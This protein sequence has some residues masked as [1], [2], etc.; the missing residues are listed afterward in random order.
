M[1][2]GGF[3]PPAALRCDAR[4]RGL[5]TNIQQAPPGA[6][7]CGRAAETL[8]GRRRRDRS[9]TLL[10]HGPDRREPPVGDLLVQTKLLVPRARRELVP[11][12]RLDA[13]LEGASTSALTVVSAPAGFGKTTLLSELAAGRAR[14]GGQH[15][16]A[17]VSLDERDVDPRRFWSY[18]LHAVERSSPGAAASALDLLESATASLESVIVALVNEVSV[19]PGDVT[20]VLDD[21]HLVGGPAVDND[22]AFLLD[23]RPPQL[24]L[25]IGTRADPALPLARLRARGELVEVRGRDLR[26][27]ADEAAAYLNGVQGLDLSASD[28]SSLESRTEGWIA[29]LQL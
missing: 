28:V 15:A 3:M 18:V 24:H 13:I 22:V 27:T 7:D 19:H 8:V 12:R 23:H 21:Y 5:L 9:S 6:N 11:R 14:E 10:L 2:S 4:G 17:W 26:F 16:I 29:A 25:V 1:R 20:L